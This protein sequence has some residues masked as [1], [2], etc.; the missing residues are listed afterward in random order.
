MKMVSQCGLHHGIQ[1]VPAENPKY[2]TNGH[3]VYENVVLFNANDQSGESILKSY[4]FSRLEVLLT[5]EINSTLK[6]PP[7]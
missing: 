6:I 4:P 5:D 2:V 3:I 1:I 7:P